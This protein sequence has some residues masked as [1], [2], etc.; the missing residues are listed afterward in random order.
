M[1][2]ENELRE[3]LKL[4]TTNLRETRRRLREVEERIQ[5]PVVIVGMSCR[6]PGGADSPQRFWDLVAAG[7]EAISEFPDDRGWDVD[8]LFDPD[9]DQAGTSYA[10]TGGFLADPAGFDAEF[11][12]I[13]PREAIAMDPQQRLL[14]ETSWAALERAGIEPGSL[15]G[16]PTGVF[17]GASGQDYGSVMAACGQDA[18]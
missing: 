18:E 13:S 10:H 14:L 7:G 5:E 6:F 16:S 8:G 15:R 4:V 12:G 2:N 9:P 11:F 1:A 3:Y 17:V